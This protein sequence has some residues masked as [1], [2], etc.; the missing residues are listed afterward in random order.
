LELRRFLRLHPGG[1]LFRIPNLLMAFPS[2]QN[3]MLGVL[4]GMA[5]VALAQTGEATGMGS[6]IRIFPRDP[7]FPKFL[8]DGTVQQFSLAKDAQTRRI[9]GSIGGIQPIAR[10]TLPGGTL[11]QVGAGATVYAS[12]IKTPS[13]LQ[14]VTADFFVDFPLEVRFSERFALRTGWGHYSAHLVD[15]G[16]EMLKLASVNYAKDYVPLFVAYS[17]P[18]VNVEM[19]GGARIDYFT[20]PE[21]NAHTIVQV[22]LQGGDLPVSTWG[23]IYGA[24]DIKA[25]SEAAGSTT[26]SYQV[27]LK[28][29]EDGP[30]GFRVAYTYRTGMDDRGQF[31]RSR[32]SV[33]LMGLY[34]DL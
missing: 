28:F 20:I 12:F 3:I 34:F 21:R 16:I 1:G 18:S 9:V 8:A 26:Q 5:P 27:G 7:L 15:D 11:V 2:W 31:Y 22:G 29:L 19:Y 10:L 24:L 4:L 14:V 13:V 25:R 32:T 17:I 6:R 33:S 23:H 30:R